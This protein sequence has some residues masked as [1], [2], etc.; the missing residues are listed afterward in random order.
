MLYFNLI[1]KH[2]ENN[3]SRF[4]DD[5]HCLTYKEL[6]YYSRAFSEQIKNL[7]PNGTILICSD[8]NLESCICILG[9]IAIGYLFGLFQTSYIYGRLHGID[10]R[11]YGS[12]NA[13][14]TN[15]L[16]TLT[17]PSFL[18]R[19]ASEICLPFTGRPMNRRPFGLFPK[20]F[21][22]SFFPVEMI[23][24]ETTGKAPAK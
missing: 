12:G 13:G 24:W 3:K 21:R 14:T 11:N 1:E 8:N 16:R 7:P 20:H 2:L 19:P 17:A 15:M 4:Q 5:L 6:N 23:R 18:R 9:C 22:C 10:I